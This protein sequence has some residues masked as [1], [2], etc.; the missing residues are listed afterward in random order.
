MFGVCVGF[1]RKKREEM[2]SLMY[3]LFCFGC[4]S[5]GCLSLSCVCVGVCACVWVYLCV[6][7]RARHC[8]SSGSYYVDPAM[9]SPPTL[10]EA[11]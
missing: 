7:R 11:W 6:C 5:Q 8:I 4:D 1:R 10:G 3:I 2:T 9:Y